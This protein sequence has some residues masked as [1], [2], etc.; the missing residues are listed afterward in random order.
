MRQDFRLD[1]ELRVG[2]GRHING[3]RLEV[4]DRPTD[5]MVGNR[6]FA[7][8][9]RGNR[10]NQPRSQAD[11]VIDRHRQRLALFLHLLQI[12][13]EM[14]TRI[15]QESHPV[16]AGHH[17]AVNGNVGLSGFGIVDN[18]HGGVEISPAVLERMH[19]HR[20]LVEVEALGL[21]DLIGW[22]L[23]AQRRGQGILVVLPGTNGRGD[24]KGDFFLGHVEQSADG[25]PVPYQTDE[26]GVGA[27]FD[28]LEQD[29]LF[30]FILLGDT[31]EFEVRINFG[32]DAHQ[33]AGL[34][35]IV[36]GFTDIHEPVADFTR[37][38]GRGCGAQGNQGGPQ[39]G[40]G[41]CFSECFH[42]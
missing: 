3:L 28:L 20:Q 38:G 13:T 39:E 1:D 30:A 26:H 36:D 33:I 2:K 16:L 11:A 31:S 42:F 23:L 27:A 7:G 5:E 24:G 41:E 40:G 18:D 35:E 22:P 32:F 6:R 37:D 21:D 10:R 34:V 17:E 15:D 19:R 14:P 4:F 9:L 12:G 25:F 8:A 29:G